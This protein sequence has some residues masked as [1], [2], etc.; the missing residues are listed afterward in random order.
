MTQKILYKFIVPSIV[1]ILACLAVSPTAHAATRTWDG[2][3]DGT[4]FSDALNWDGDAT[5]PTTDDDLV[6]PVDGNIDLDTDIELLSITSQND[7]AVFISTATNTIIVDDGTGNLD[8]T[9]ESTSFLEVGVPIDMTNGS[10]TADSA[11]D[12][13]VVLGLDTITGIG[14]DGFAGSNA[15]IKNG[16]GLLMLHAGSTYDG[17][18]TVNSGFL[19]AVGVN[20]MGTVTGNTIIN[21]GASL[22]IVNENYDEADLTVAEPLTLNGV[23]ATASTESLASTPKIETLLTGILC[24][25]DTDEGYGSCSSSGDVTLSGDITTTSDLPIG[26]N[27]N[28][29]SLTGALDGSG[30]DITLVDGSAGSLIING[31]SNNTNTANSTLEPAAYSTTL[32]D[33]NANNLYVGANS[34]VTVNGTRGTTG[35]YNGGVLKGTGTVGALTVNSGGI[36]APG[37]SPGCLASGDLSLVSGA[38]FEVEIDGNTV[39]TEYDQQQVTGT[40]SLGDATLDIQKLAS[41]TPVL[42][43]EFIIIDN[44][45]ADA[46]TGTFLNYAEGSTRVVDG[47]IFQISYEG[48]DGNDVVLSVTDSESVAEDDPAAP[49]TGFAILLANPIA[50]FALTSISAIAIVVLA[51]KSVLQK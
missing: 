38:T 48:G 9:A 44:D 6:F 12:A 36:L 40:V 13:A 30:Y 28:S 27:D 46:V 23:P 21:N 14:F 43:D 11:T 2:G 3:G 50:T 35:V 31:S 5:A 7:A 8:I 18:I 16:A 26:V 39:C 42:G 19:Y 10:I 15:I 51:R 24:A 34:I 33:S 41:F 20:G 1:F 37:E 49:D 17:V 29:L 45:G 47:I 32:S 25:I 4:T 22:Y